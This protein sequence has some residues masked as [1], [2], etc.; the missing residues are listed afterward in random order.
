MVTLRKPGNFYTE[1]EVDA[2]LATISGGGTNNHDELNNLDYENSGHTGFAS[3]EVLTSASG[4]LQSQIDSK[5][6]SSH[7]HDDRY[8]TESE[9]DV[10]LTTVSGTT[11]HAVLNNLDYESSGHTGFASSVNITTLSGA[12]QSEIDNKADLGHSHD[13]LYYTEAETDNFITTLSGN[14]QSEIDTKSDSLHLHD[15]RYYTETEVDGL[16]TTLSGQIIEDH[17]SLNNLDYDNSGHTGFASSA[18]LASVSGTLQVDIDN[19]AD[20]LHLH[21][22]RYYTESEIDLILSTISGGGGTVDHSAL[23]NLDYASSGH[24]GFASSVDITTLSGIL[25]SDIDSK[26][27]IGHSHNDLYYTEAEIDG[28]IASASGT[29]D[30]SV[31]NNLDYA[32]SGHTGFASSELLTSTS[33]ILQNNIDT[34]LDSV[35]YIQFNTTP[36][37]IVNSPGLLSWDTESDTLQLSMSGGLVRQQIGEEVFLPGRVYNNTSNTLPNG[38]PVYVTGAGPEGTYVDL[39]TASGVSTSFVVGL[40]NR[41]ILPGELG[42]VSRLGEILDLD[43]SLFFSGM[44]LWLGTEP[45]TFINHPPEAPHMH[46]FL[47]Y[48]SKGLSTVSGS[49]V[50]SPIIMPRLVDLSGVHESSL[51]DFDV[52]YW[53]A[54][55]LR[56]EFTNISGCHNHNNIYYTEEEINSL[57]TTLSGQ[58]I[59][60]HSGLSELDYASSGHTGFASSAALS[61]VSGTLQSDI[62]T[63]SDSLHLH[64]DRYYTESEIDSFLTTISG[65]VVTDHSALNN[66]DY[67]SSGHTGFASTITLTTVSGD[68]QNNIDAKADSSHLHDDR[69]YTENEVDGLLTTL[70]GQVITNHNELNNL[71]YASSGH[72]GFASS[73]D[74]TTLSGVLQSEIDSKSDISHSHN[75][76]YY[77]ETE[78][79]NL[80][81]TLSGNLQSDIDS[82][83]DSSHLHDDRYYT[84]AEVDALITTISGQLDDHNELNNLDYV[85]SGHTGF[86]SSV[87]LST[88]SGTLQSNIDTKADV[89][90]LHDDRYYTESE[91]DTISGTL[92]SD[93]DGKSDLGHTHDDRYYTETETGGLLTTLSGFLQSEIDT[94]S[95]SSHIHDDRYYTETEIDSTLTTLSGN[96]SNY[97]DTK[98]VESFPTTTA[99][100]AVIFSNGTN[101]SEDVSNLYWDN[102]NKR[103]GVGSPATS[104]KLSVTA[105]GGSDD[106]VQVK[107]D[108]SKSIFNIDNDGRILVSPDDIDWSTVDGE[109]GGA[110][111]YI[112]RGGPG[113]ITSIYYNCLSLST[114]D[115]DGTH[116]NVYGFIASAQ[117]LKDGAQVVGGLC[118]ASTPMFEMAKTFEL[119]GNSVSLQ[120]FFT[121]ISEATSY[122]DVTGALLGASVSS[123]YGTKI[124]PLILSGTT[125]TDYYGFYYSPSLDSSTITNGYALYADFPA[126][127]TN[128]WGVYITGEDNNYFSG[129]VSISGSVVASNLS[130]TNTGDQ[131]LS[132]YATLSNLTS[133]S[134]TLQSEIDDKSDLGHVHDERYY[135]ESEVNGLVTTV[136]GQIIKDH[137]ELNNLDY[138]SSGHTGFAS[139]EELSTASGTLQ[140]EIDGK[141]NL[142][143]THDDRY[144]TE[145]E[146]DLTI[147]TLSG[148]L[149]S[150]IDSKSDSSHLHDDRYYTESEVDGLLTTV[151]GQ[152]VKDHNELNNLD[153]ASSGHTGFASLLNLAT[154]SGILQTDIDDKSDLGHIHPATEVTYVDSGW[155]ASNVDDMLDS[156]SSYSED[157]LMTSRISPKFPLSV[158]GTGTYTLY[159][160][161]GE[162]YI[163]YPGVH[164]KVNW[165]DTQLDT[166]G[167]STGVNYVSIDELENINIR[168]AQPDLNKEISLGYVFIGADSQASIVYNCGS[169]GSGAFNSIAY[170]LL[171]LGS[172]IY[173]NGGSLVLNYGG[174][175]RAIASTACRVQNAFVDYSLTEASSSDV[176]VRFISYFYAPDT[177][178]SF[179]YHFIFYDNGLVNNR[180]NDTTASGATTC[181]GSCTFTNSSNIVTC[182]S[183]LT[184]YISN[185]NLIYPT[186]WVGAGPNP[187]MFSVAVSGT[188]WTGSQTNIHLYDNWNWTTVS[189]SPILINKAVPFIPEGKYATHLV[190]RTLD[191]YFHLVLGTELFDS[192][193][194]AEAGAPPDVPVAVATTN[195]KIAKLIV[196]PD[197]TEMTAVDIRPLPFHDRNTGGT[198]GSSGSGGVTDHGELT[199]LNDD[200]HVLY[201]PSNASRDFTSVV[202]YNNNKSFVEDNNLISKKYADDLVTTTSGGLQNEIDGKSD[203]SH[204]HDDR[205]YTETETD[206]FITTLSGNLQS[207]IDTKSDSSHLHDDRYYTESEVDN[208]V[209][210]VSGNIVENTLEIITSTSGVLQS[211]IDGKSALGHIHDDRYYTESEVDSLIT[212]ISGQIIEDH[213]ALNNLDYASSGHTGFASSA[214]LSTTSGTLQSNIDG[215]S[216]LGHTH[217]DRY[218]TEAEVDGFIT[219]ISGNIIEDHSALNNLDYASSGHTGFAS[220]DILTSMSGILQSD[221]DGK[222]DL[223]HVHDD[224]Y[225]TESEVDLTFTTLSGTLQSKLD[226]KSDLGHTH[227]DRYYTDSEIDSLITT[228]SGQ[229]V[230]DHSAL[231]NLDYAS[232]GHTGFASSV[233]VTTLSGVLQSEIDGKSDLG[234][235]HDDRYYT[236]SEIDLTITTL[237]GNLQ[238]NIDEKSDLGHTH[239]DRYYTESE[240][241]SFL[242]TI[243]G[244]MVEDHNELNN[245]DYASSGHT[246]FVST[247]VLTSTSGILQSE[248]DGKS[249]LGHTHD[250]RYYTESEVDSNLTTLSGSLQSNIDGKSDLGHTHDDRYYTESEVDGLITTVSGLIIDDH[251]ELNNLDYASSGHTG[252]A[253]SSDLSSHTGGTGAD[254]SYI[255][256]DVTSSGTPTFTTVRDKNKVGVIEIKASNNLPQ[257]A[258]WCDGSAVSRSTYSDLFSD[259]GTTWGVGDGSTT[260]NLPNLNGTNSFPRGNSTAGGTGGSATH[261]HS[262]NPPS[263]TSSSDGAHTHT[264]DPPNTTSD[265]GTSHTHSVN[266]PNTTSNSTGDHT[267]TVNPPNTTTTTESSTENFREGG[268]PSGY[269]TVANDGHTHNVDIAQFNSGTDGDHS[270]TVDIAEFTS[271]GESSHTHNVNIAQFNS[272]SDGAHTH[273]VDITSFT[274]GSGDNLPPYVN[275]KYFIWY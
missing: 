130:G 134:G 39:A 68:L 12:L 60:N 180:Y 187:E 202:S 41:D 74:I 113:N 206:N 115:T 78:T 261:T 44:P 228:I 24:I 51:E 147:T 217:D 66:L 175:P 243:S 258:L 19:K 123:M 213:S 272:G 118:V 59:S 46:V 237:S 178:W 80:L 162:G 2:L 16:L 188:E 275:V 254:H 73:A 154:T 136:S 204:T 21:D 251:N 229:V 211:E 109:R 114:Q 234:H 167:W 200:D 69:Y 23:I 250:D 76:L 142:G 13:D 268:W 32:S 107:T 4:V 49:V 256:Q 102:E 158:S 265:G 259:L 226:G 189:G 9:V 79:D 10:L 131:D 145:T 186:T 98:N 67:N 11:D 166:H 139:S 269:V 210:T 164:K 126:G 150:D 179:D 253:S 181:S 106:L 87:A 95:D 3:S 246:G 263:T 93:I 244:Q 227:D 198:G 185:G 52:L 156:I 215:K 30:H 65:Q 222:S 22:D 25:Q 241:D 183:D 143:H 127:V 20:S 160:G 148:N 165:S 214:I 212:T 176:G 192:L 129:N 137:N 99:S 38:A 138:V 168:V 37:G 266:P 201:I 128:S 172:F 34:L 225:Y 47:G 43:T 173:D 77:T 5:A 224:R 110:L 111:M 238:S 191:N 230:T 174:T 29:T 26:S 71:D 161:G 264:V 152:I 271:G 63:K 97:F 197:T 103:L 274:S 248:I 15:D 55:N 72:T 205:Y 62:D 267:H 219:T 242:T 135:T 239:D 121:P 255:D 199:G 17:S 89:S 193:E 14:L 31:L 84:E 88:T 36:S 195:I 231:N 151:S 116:D 42:Y 96:I 247:N 120:G 33:G 101:L 141:S 108:A 92:Q 207:E 194:E 171:R 169:Y 140:S 6:D 105:S 86:A 81:T 119:I 232:S 100:G 218:Y 48:V 40:I 260:F 85:S 270:H 159:I 257:Y 240:V 61:S 56:F 149:Q 28:L 262:I 94:K 27:D 177:D 53:N 54:D 133:A 157:I 223:G 75:E 182:P 8:Y 203:L 273:T 184:S 45:G 252:F 50:F 18:A 122:S 83:S 58:I 155:S 153:Y 220:F 112:R 124:G 249:D 91:I 163:N 190:A 64:D 70:S 7:L 82:K 235:L 221:I 57:I 196:T 245:L 216:D 144:Y 209:T 104:Y 132:L 208:I 117:G 146:I 90:H 125:I 35:D 170:H 236:E 1:A 233:D